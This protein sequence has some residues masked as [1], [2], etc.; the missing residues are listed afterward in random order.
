[1]QTDLK[2]DLHIDPK[3]APNPDLLDLQAVTRQLGQHTFGPFSLTITRGERIA[4]LGPSG[5]GKSTL[6]KL[7]AH[8]LSPSAG[9]V[10]LKQRPLHQWHVQELSRHRAVLPQSCDIAFGLSTDLVISLGRVARNHDP[11]L[12]DIVRASAALAHASHLLGRRTDTLSGGEL[13]RIQLARLFAQLWDCNNS[14]ILVDEPLAALDPGLQFDLLNS[15]DRYATARQHAV[16]AILHDM[17]QAVQN[18]DRLLLIKD[19]T[20]FG[21]MV[22]RAGQGTESNADTHTGSASVTEP[23]RLALEALYGIALGYV[24]DANYGF[25]IIPL[26]RM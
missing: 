10:L 3:R 8:E 22:C 17:N 11:L 16:I 25:V 14:V 15:L 21:D 1:M 19:G 9:Q 18:F 12:N 26:R 5:A 2:P 23:V 24:C 20:L 4:I 13:A 6:L 7:M